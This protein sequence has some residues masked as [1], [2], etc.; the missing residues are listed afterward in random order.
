MGRK[1]S[2]RKKMQKACSYGIVPVLAQEPAEK[3]APVAGSACGKCLRCEEFQEQKCAGLP[4][5]WGPWCKK[6]KKRCYAWQSY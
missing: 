3:P 5:Y 2:A 6:Q 4:E 1:S